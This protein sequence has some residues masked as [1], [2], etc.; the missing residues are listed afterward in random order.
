M[1]RFPLCFII[2]ILS[3]VLTGCSGFLPARTEISEYDVTEIAGIDKCE[4]DP[5]LIEVTMVSRLK[6]APSGSGGGNDLVT[7][8]SAKGSTIFEAQLK[9]KANAPRR[10]FFGYVDYIL[11]G[12][13]AAKD[14]FLKYFN[15]LERDHEIRKSANVYIVKDG[16]A[17]ELLY[18]T[19][20]EDAF[21][22]EKL[23]TAKKNVEFISNTK[24]T[25]IID[26]SEMIEGS[27]LIIPS[28][29]YADYTDEKIIGKMPEKRLG[30]GGYAVFK[31]STLAG[32]IDEDYARGY[33][34]IINKV[35]SF[36]VNVN[37]ETGKLAC[38]EVVRSKTKVKAQFEGEKLKTVVLDTH[39][40]SHFPEQQSHDNIMNR[41]NVDKMSAEL[42]DKA[43]KDM[44]KVIKFS[45][46]AKVDCL[47]IGQRLKLLYPYKWKKIENDW[48]KLYPELDIKVRIDSHLLLNYDIDRPAGSKKE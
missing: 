2:L 40:L 34:V 39:I 35:G 45:Q 20:S 13:A 24:E 15:M 11:I 38:L 26:V 21:V 41:S 5:S 32:F 9:L 48:E 3:A 42:S 27:S 1:K 12:E 28:L 30:L 31:D 25:K 37:D 36:P 44:E 14:D 4:E 7:I 33:N 10:L 22:T 46:N 6:K 16:T 17:K 29:T 47:K 43:K 8:T 18:S 23:D 19:S